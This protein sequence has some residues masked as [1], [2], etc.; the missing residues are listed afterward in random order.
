MPPGA[1]ARHPNGPQRRP[2]AR[3]GG[4]ETA[5]SG[6]GPNPCAV[7]LDESP[8]V[9]ATTT[10]EPSPWRIAVPSTVTLTGIWCGL[11]S[12]A[13]APY[14]PYDA[15]LALIGA[16]LCDMIDGRVARLVGAR[17]KFGAELDSLADIVS[18]GLAP[19]WLAYH[20]S[21]APVTDRGF[22]PWLWMAF[23]FVAGGAIRLARFGAK[24]EGGG[25]T[26][27][28]EGMPIPVAAMLIVTLVMA[29][30][31][32]DLPQLREPMVMGTA[33]GMCSVLMVSR[34]PLPS[35]K[36][37]P[38]RTAQIVFYGLIAGGLLMLFLRRPGGTVLLG[39]I[40]IY[41]GRGVIRWIVRS[42]GG[43]R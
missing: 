32:V 11:L 10:T 3:S 19:A 13:W 7:V 24:L 22:D 14:R 28:F 21:L 31:E 37:F 33:L 25:A 4:R 5:Q 15:C 17:S 26:D 42:L 16:A 6:V 12:I 34:L 20:W 8:A 2:N 18:F 43:A 30:H 23:A 41:L 35:Y 1:R 9:T 40:G 39:F 29:S 38:S 27:E 36:R